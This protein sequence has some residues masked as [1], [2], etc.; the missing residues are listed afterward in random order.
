MKQNEIQD[1]YKMRFHNL[2]VKHFLSLTGGYDIEKDYECMNKLIYGGSKITRQQIK[3]V[4]LTTQQYILQLQN[5]LNL[6]WGFQYVPIKSQD[7]IGFVISFNLSKNISQL[8]IH[9]SDN[10]FQKQLKQI[11]LNCYRKFKKEMGI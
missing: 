8:K 3:F 5:M 11:V 7:G 9:K 10:E 6:Y 2:F 4:L 1:H